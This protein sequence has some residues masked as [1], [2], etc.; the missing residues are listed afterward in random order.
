VTERIPRNRWR[1]DRA[2]VFDVRRR[3]RNRA[4]EFASSLPWSWS[5]DPIISNDLPVEPSRLNLA[6]MTVSLV[7]ACFA[8][9]A[10]VLHFVSYKLKKTAERKTFHIKDAT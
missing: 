6:F 5:I 7:T 8:L 9:L 4:A 3:Y 1:E 2:G 10:A